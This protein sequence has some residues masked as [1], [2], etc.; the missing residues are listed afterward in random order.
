MCL[1]EPQITRKPL[2]LN[3]VASGRLFCLKAIAAIVLLVKEAYKLTLGQQITVV[4]PHT[5]KSIIRQPP[6]L[7]MTNACSCDMLS[8]ELLVD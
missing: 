6:D 4:A 7:W 3:P 5:L 2:K 8:H 1:C